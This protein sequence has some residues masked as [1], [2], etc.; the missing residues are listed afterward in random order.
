MT[1]CYLPP[2]KVMYN[3]FDLRES[4]SQFF[5][6]LD[7]KECNLST[8]GKVIILTLN[9]TP[10]PNIHI[11][12]MSPCIFLYFYVI[13]SLFGSHTLKSSSA[14]FYLK[15]GWVHSFL[16]SLP[17]WNVTWNCEE[18]HPFWTNNTRLCLIRITG[19]SY[20]IFFLV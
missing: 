20:R 6:K 14:H 17:F 15:G 5:R 13:L 16:E 8:R 1:T 7:I 19:T 3:L 11:R 4:L 10:F 12:T 18:K 2:L 9:H